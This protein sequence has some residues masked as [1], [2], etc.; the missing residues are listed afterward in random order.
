MQRLALVVRHKLVTVEKFLCATMLFALMCIVSWG[1]IERY[2]LKIGTGWPD[3]L[4]RYVCIYAMMFGASLGVVRGSHIGV[5][6]FVRVLPQAWQK[7][8]EILGYILCGIFTF[9]LALVGWQYFN[10]LLVANQLT[11]TMEF[12]IAYAYL[13]I[14]VGALLMTLHYVIKLLTIN[15]PDGDIAGQQL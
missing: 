6:V 3:E 5:E 9:S 13:A 15:A 12:P 4:S 14:P 2:I 7:R 10:K 8:I 11:P 1:I